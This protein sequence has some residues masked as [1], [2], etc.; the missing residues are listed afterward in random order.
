[1]KNT[2]LSKIIMHAYSTS[3]SYNNIM[4]DNKIDP[5]T[6]T[7]KEDLDKLPLFDK[8]QMNEDIGNFLSLNYNYNNK[9]EII[10]QKTVGTTGQPFVV[11]WTKH[12]YECSLSSQWIHR[13]TNFGINPSHR[14][15]SFYNSEGLK[16]IPA[17]RI[18]NNKQEISFNKR[19]LDDEIFE[20]YYE[21]MLFY[22][23][24]WLYIQPSIAYML[25]SFISQNGLKVPSSIKYIELIGDYL[26]PSYRTT[27]NNAFG[28][29]IC[30]MY[31]CT[32]TNGIAYECSK[33]NLHLISHNVVVEI[34]K[35][36][37]PVDYGQEGDVYITSLCNTAMPIIRYRL[38]D[39]AILLPYDY[40]DCGNTEPIIKI[41]PN[42]IGEF[43]FSGGS[44]SYKTS[45]IVYPIERT[46]NFLIN[47]Q[48][49]KFQIVQISDNAFTTFFIKNNNVYGH[50]EDIR[51]EFISEL[52]DF[53]YKNA[54]WKISF[55]DSPLPNKQTGIFKSERV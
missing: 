41:T 50:E 7:T 49:I 51:N 30:N 52:G 27:I 11:L 39:R 42:R 47:N 22:K 37:V 10:M 43:L 9:K 45:K 14:F 55:I 15:C 29:P 32:E 23:P 2:L 13:N 46:P 25:S 44:E 38:G 5:E 4:N 6:I 28:V 17:I 21:Q 24:D 3:P 54:E 20:I 19:Y 8:E 36:G 16:R 12:D 34:L 1:M 48:T 31:W 18:I 53:G 40:C 33:R 26:F 35:N